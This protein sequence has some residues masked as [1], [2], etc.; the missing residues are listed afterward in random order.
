MLPPFGTTIRRSRFQ[1]SVTREMTGWWWRWWPLAGQ[2]EYHAPVVA[3]IE[4]V[5]V[6]VVVVVGGGGGGRPVGAGGGGGGWM[7]QSAGLRRNERKARLRSGTAW[8]RRLRER[9]ARYRPIRDAIFNRQHA[10][11]RSL[12][13]VLRARRR[14]LPRGAART[15]PTPAAP[16]DPP[17]WRSKFFSPAD[18]TRGGGRPRIFVNGGKERARVASLFEEGFLLKLL[19]RSQGRGDATRGYWRRC[20]EPMRWDWKWFLGWFD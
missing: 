8:H 18:A 12:R 7:C 9:V 20:E 2:A 5:M 1:P 13:H 17:W 4:E 19:G 15:R 6:V 3:I 14:V 11:L 16:M 10:L